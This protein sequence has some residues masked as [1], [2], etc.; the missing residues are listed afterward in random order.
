MGPLYRNHRVFGWEVARL[1]VPADMG[2]ELVILQTAPHKQ[3]VAPAHLLI[4]VT[5]DEAA[6]EARM[7]LVQA[8]QRGRFL[9]LSN[10]DLA[11][12]FAA[13]LDRE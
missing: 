7:A 2:R 11:A 4:P 6:F 13:E 10:A 3:E 1:S 5:P 8:I 12:L 9:G